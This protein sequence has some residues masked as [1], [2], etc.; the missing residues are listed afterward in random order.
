MVDFLSRLCG[1]EYGV[2]YLKV[3]DDFLSRLCGGEWWS[4]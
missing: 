3:V 4:C 1:G 2:T